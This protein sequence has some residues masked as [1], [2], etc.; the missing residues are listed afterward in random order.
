MDAILFLSAISAVLVLLGL[1][2][3]TTGADTRDGFGDDAWLRASGFNTRG[4]A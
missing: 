3:N 4:P 1:A 2:A